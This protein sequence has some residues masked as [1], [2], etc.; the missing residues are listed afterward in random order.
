MATIFP[1]HVGVN[2]EYI[3]KFTVSLTHF[4]GHL[5]RYYKN[6]RSNYQEHL[7]AL[8]T[9]R[10]PPLPLSALRSPVGVTDK[11]PHNCMEYCIRLLLICF[12]SYVILKDFTSS[13]LVRWFRFFL[14]AAAVQCGPWHLHSRCFLFTHNDAPQSVGLLWT[15]DQLAAETSTRQHITLTTDRHPYPR[16]DLNPRS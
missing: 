1:K 13:V 16:W 7:E 14:H 10:I 4:V 3:K 15:S 8:G 2:L 12:Y 5:K 9:E 6:A 11:R